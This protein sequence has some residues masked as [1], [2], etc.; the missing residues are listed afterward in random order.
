MKPRLENI[1]EFDVKEHPY[2]LLP[3][4]KIELSPVPDLTRK[5]QLTYRQFGQGQS[6]VMLHGLWSSAYRFRHLIQPLSS[7]YR[8]ILPELQDPDG[9]YTLPQINYSLETLAVLIAEICRALDLSR[10]VIVGEGESG[11]AGILLGLTQ[12]EKISALVVISAVLSPSTKTKLK[13]WLLRLP[14]LTNRWAKNGFQRPQ[15]AA[16]SMLDYADPSLFS[17][18]EIR[19]LALSFRTWP[20]AKAKTQVLAQTLSTTYRQ[21]LSQVIQE[22]QSTDKS[23]PVPLK[24]IYGKVASFASPEQG[25]MLRRLFP[26]AELFVDEH[27]AGGVH[28]ENPEW[29]AKIIA[30]LVQEAEKLH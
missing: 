13:G 27:S 7:Q 10:P 3:K 9:M 12:P 28:V 24:L 11:L 2:F 22:Y 14:F 26:G 5:L 20:R 16:M 23:F 21:K 19:Q 29:T 30:S 18:Q 4:R 17:R 8:L 25:E 15:Q 6:I 1:P